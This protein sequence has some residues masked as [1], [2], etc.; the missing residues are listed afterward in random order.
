MLTNKTIGFIGAGNMA[1]ALIKGLTGSG[2]I[3]AAQVIA[4]DSVKE[5]LVHIAETYEVKVFN[6]NYEVAEGSDIII[7][8]LKPGDMKECVTEI[9]PDLGT[10]KLL[11]S[12]AAGVTTDNVHMWLKAAGLKVEVAVVR[13]MPNTPA[14]VGEGITGLVA[15]R[16]AG[17][18]ELEIAQEIFTQVGHVV[19]FDDET[20]LDAVTGLSGSGPAY[21]CEFV[22][23]LTEGGE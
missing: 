3:S 8:A 18:A 13:A 20:L 5:R 11:I 21:V 4:S 23:A 9:A 2:K 1:E 14:T 15:G 7:L 10:E 17:K 16:N 12:V 19:I 6:K 22:E